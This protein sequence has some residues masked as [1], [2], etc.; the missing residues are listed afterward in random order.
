[1]SNIGTKSDVFP[2]LIRDK[3]KDKGD[4]EQ[5]RVLPVKKISLFMVTRIMIGSII[6][7][8]IVE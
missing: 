6:Y 5:S 3:E 8:R 7:V 2:L 1:M 4:V